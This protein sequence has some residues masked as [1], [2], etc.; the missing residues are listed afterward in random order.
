M[1]HADYEPPLPPAL[2]SKLEQEK[3]TSS[4]KAGASNEAVNTQGYNLSSTLFDQELCDHSLL[5][6]K[7][8]TYMSSNKKPNIYIHI[9][10]KTTEIMR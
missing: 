9:Y 5:E 10:S 7:V 2:S 8:F 4:C 6:N 3:L 1:D